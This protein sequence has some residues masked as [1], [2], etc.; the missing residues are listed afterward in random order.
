M[1]LPTHPMQAMYQAIDN[2]LADILSGSFGGP[3]SW[4]FSTSQEDADNQEF[5]QAIAWGSHS[6]SQAA[7]PPT[8]AEP[9][10]YDAGL[11]Q[12]FPGLLPARG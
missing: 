3:D 4:P 8:I 2:R 1:I 10:G 6:C 11:S 9:L 7:T 5:K 12:R